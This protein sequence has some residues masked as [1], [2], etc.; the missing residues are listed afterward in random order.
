MVSNCSIEGI[1]LD[2][3]LT[4]GVNTG[5]DLLNRTLPVF[6]D[7]LNCSG[8]LVIRCTGQDVKVVSLQGLSKAEEKLLSDDAAELF[9]KLSANEQFCSID[10]K[11]GCCVFLLS[12]FGLLALCFRETPQS[13]VI[14]QFIPV[15][16][17]LAKACKVSEK[18]NSLTIEKTNYNEERRLLHAIIEN[19]PDPIYVKDIEGYKILLNKAEA[20][21]LGV[22]DISEVIGKKDSDFYTEDVALRTEAEDQVIINEGK[23]VV[24]RDGI[25]TTQS[26]KDIWL[27]GTKIPHFDENGKVTGIIGISHNISE[28]KKIEN[29]LR[30]V[31][32][33]YESIFNSFV[34]LYY[35]SD[36]SGNILDLSPSV[37]QL[38]GYRPQELVGKSVAH[39]YA[40]IESRNRMIQLLV[41]KGSINDYE[42][43]LIHKNG[44]LVP[45]S[46]TS[47]LIKDSEGK[48]GYIEGTIRD[49]S[50]RKEV[51]EKL[52]KL[53]VLQNLLTH[54]ATEFIN[55]PVEDSDKAVNRLLSVVGEGNEI[56]RVC[57]FEYDFVK[58]TM[59]NTHEWCATG[60][61]PEIENLQQIPT[62]LFPNWVEAHKLGDLLVIQD[63][64][65]L[66]KHDP[67]YNLLES[68]GIKT[69]ITIPLILNNECIG[70]VGFD[71]VKSVKTWS[72]D[73]ITFLHILADLLCNVTDRKKKDEAL[74]N[75]EAS[76][77]AIFNNVPFQMWLKDVDSNYLTI[78][79]P[80][81]EYFSITDESEII[82]KDALDIWN[83]ET[84][85][86]FIEEDQSVMQNLE[87]SSV[88]E[89]VDFK[90]K[91]VWFEIFR[92]PIIDDNGQLLGTTGIAR[93]ITSRKKADEALQQAVAAAEA[94]NEAKSKFLAIMSHEIRN[95]L[96]AV[97]GMT[98]MLNDAGITG[99][100]SKLIENIKTSS[101][102]LLM[103]INDVLDFS[104]IESGEMLLEETSFNIQ[105]VIGR[106]FNSN[107]FIAKEKNI[108]LKYTIDSRI[109][110][111]HKGD[112]LRL[113]QVLSNLVS[114]AIK[115]TNE[116]EIEIRCA[117]EM[118]HGQYS[119]VRFEV[120][121]TGIGISAENQEKVFESF[122]QENNTISR[123]HGGSG[124]GLAISKQI[125]ELM[126]GKLKL[127]STK[128][129]GSK[130]YF[131]IDL[132]IDESQFVQNIETGTDAEGSSLKGYSVLLVED[133]KLNQILAV[134][135][136][137][138]W[139]AQ[140]KVVNNGQQAVDISETE[141]FDIILMDIQM[142][143]M[144][145]MTASKIIREKLRIS[146]PILA[147]SANVI[148]GIVE[149]CEEAGMQGYIS[150]PFDADDLLKKILVHV[151]KSK[152]HTEASFSI[153]EKIVVSDVSRLMKMIGSDQ[154]QLNIML[155]KFLEITPSYL[156]ELNKGDS[157]N[158][159]KA[160]AT[161][162]HKIKSSIDLVSAPVMR[163][164]I[165]KINQVSK[166]GGEITEVKLLIRQ[167]NAYYKL[168]EFQ[169]RE[170][171]NS[172]RMLK[173]VG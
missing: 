30:M 125:V 52:N 155:D 128:N 131:S 169:L 74:R 142:P 105:D 168:L 7:T 144:D 54:L 149:R 158:D 101:D 45:V 90:H 122:K 106:V 170:E 68:Q 64:S 43:L 100:N 31:A 164:L 46:I 59:S 20:D 137:E 13:A 146:T 42:N 49:I 115:F 134:A 58:N 121:D 110:N 33:K 44:K 126:G 35:R 88:E 140:V 76:L 71:S 99:P 9:A 108:E 116:G 79:K 38:S 113:Q 111:C 17:V 94:A 93:D 21:L 57:I 161:S 160:I 117:F 23:L 48:P 152:N 3:A 4:I 97:V 82:G 103:I 120:L 95:P 2:L 6:V 166:N 157:A 119:S 34:D 66:D 87:L 12:D 162:A 28:Y 163:D 32:E 104:K 150:K 112:P 156:E 51:E 91:S 136:L 19:I 96:N 145:G 98:R 11:S 1:M 39:V 61:S 26:G 70:F 40:D 171:I 8:G 129:I 81:M 153:E 29:E 141:T 5:G 65:K 67:Q 85:R 143:V 18:L 148:K 123:T 135:I 92:A 114:N 47:H 86:H 130:F 63:V 15:V 62:N 27:Q 138:K 73:E 36:L 127:E 89:L 41:E 16:N 77:K 132:K 55:I 147:L 60:I 50:E 37:Y 75:R 56:D 167:F 22:S 102:H 78:N 10:E 172:M 159:L 109:N 80:F 124:L 25:L 118:E 84:A 83:H 107:V 72:S 24:H 139:G 14:E 151:S 154:I 173:Q 165:L 69:L 133:N 53:L